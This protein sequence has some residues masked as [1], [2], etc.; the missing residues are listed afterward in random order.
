VLSGLVFQLFN[1]VGCLWVSSLFVL[2]AALIS[3]KLPDPQP[4]GASSFA[5][6]KPNAWKA[7]DGD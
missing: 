6:A 4:Q 1:L 5:T 7:G 2:A 3:L